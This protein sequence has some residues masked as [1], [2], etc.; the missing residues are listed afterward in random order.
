[1]VWE[2]TTVERAEAAARAERWDD[3]AAL[4]WTAL[5]EARV[6]NDAEALDRVRALA[7][8]I[9]HGGSASA[10]RE[11]TMMSELL[12]AS[13]GDV[14]PQPR[15]RWFLRWRIALVVGVVLF[16]FASGEIASLVNHG[17]FRSPTLTAEELAAPP[18]PVGVTAEEGV[19]L[20]P[21]GRFPSALLG[22]A[23]ARMRLRFPTVPVHVLHEMPIERSAVFGRQLSAEQL[24]EQIRSRYGSQPAGRMIV[25]LTVFDMRASETRWSFSLGA[26]DRVAVVATARMNPDNYIGLDRWFAD[27]DWR[28][29]KMLTRLTA[30]LYW[31]YTASDDSDDLLYERIGSLDQ[32]D[33]VGGELPPRG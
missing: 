18:G 1:M 12:G 22:R 6:G 30:F 8:R 20:Q 16:V 26:T 29:D 4:L 32:L 10:R 5:E 15:R 17:W 28:L 11:A 21:L 23:A 25:G 33:A 24:V 27:L 19:Y 7:A 2:V 13:V 9:A 14:Q 3:A 31:G